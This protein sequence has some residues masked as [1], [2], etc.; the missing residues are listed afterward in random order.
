LFVT[1][2]EEERERIK[3]SFVLALLAFL[4]LSLGIILLTIFAVAL[5]WEQGWIAAIGLLALIYLGVGAGAAL[6][7]R[8]KIFS[9]PALFSSTLA[10]LGKDRDQLKASTLE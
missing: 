7:L 1:E 9:R 6:R 10:E 2:L 5:F 8:K 3:Q 4:G